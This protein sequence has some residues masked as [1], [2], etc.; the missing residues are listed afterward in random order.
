MHAPSF[1]R[2]LSGGKG[3]LFLISFGAL[4]VLGHAPLYIWPA[5]IIGL[6][7]LM[8]HLDGARA[9]LLRNDSGRTALSKALFWRGARAGYL[10]GF[11]YFLASLYWI[12]SAFITRGS[13]YVFLAPLGM[14]LLPAGLALFWG[15]AGGFY[16][17]LGTKIKRR[18]SR[19][20]LFTALLFIAEILRG[21][22]LSGF[23]WNLP[24]YIWQAG[25]AMSQSA[26]LFGIYGLS[27][28]TLFLAASLAA[29]VTQGT[30]GALI[31][32]R[33]L[34]PLIVSTSLMLSL[35]LFGTQRLS[36]AQIDYWDGPNIRVLQT[37]IDQL[38]KYEQGG[39][40]S[41]IDQYFTLSLTP[42][43]EDLT[44]I[45]WPEGAIPGLPLEDAN[46]MRAINKLILDGPDLIMGVTRR[47]PIPASYFEPD[48]E[49]TRYYNSVIG[50]R[51]NPMGDRAHILGL[52][53]KS[54]LVP[55][56]E[57]VPG[58]QMAE[59]LNIP[60]LTRATASFDF[61]TPSLTKFEGLP[62]TSIQICYEA[63][64]T[65]FTGKAI[66]QKPDA[67]RPDWILTVSNDAWFGRTSGPYQH[68]NQVRYRA[69][70]EGLPIVRSAS[71]GLSGFVDPY[72]RMIKS[73][74]LN[75]EGV[76]DNA[77]PKPISQP[78][79]SK[80]RN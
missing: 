59:A 54:R 43:I 32:P 35:F 40:D 13:F 23:P 4:S 78:M 31:H 36:S 3:A 41:L 71:S 73:L 74:P 26:A 58:N 72:G 45:I 51:S 75:H 19:A 21:H 50:L 37:R 7:S 53:N 68:M 8:L 66:S 64:F 24:G 67:P 70:E 65:G 80:I 9:Q 30:S 57:F 48:N 15:L 34:A 63:I 5:F 25:G 79:I 6:A 46:L 29:G 61:G 49:A 62:R 11:G 17:W 47:D 44:H 2:N 77:L 60:A 38:T 39:Y 76:I 16:V 12:A 22:M 55:F 52:Y 1:V 33:R 18:A 28:L 42:P 69:I 27:A 14:V 56:G 10:F 20:L